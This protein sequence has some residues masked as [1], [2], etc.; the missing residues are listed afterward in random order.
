MMIATHPQPLSWEERGVTTKVGT[1]RL[2]LRVPLLLEEKGS[3][4]PPEAR[5][6]GVELKKEKQQSFHDIILRGVVNAQ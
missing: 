5:R 6:R 4:C 2:Y 3:A 1:L